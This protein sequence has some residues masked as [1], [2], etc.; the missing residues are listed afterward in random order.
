[1]TTTN[2]Q[3]RDPEKYGNQEKAASG[4]I[5]VLAIATLLALLVDKCNAQSAY[6][7][8]TQRPG[9]EIYTYK[10]TTPAAADSI[11]A[12]IVPGFSTA[13]TMKNTLYFEQETEQMHVYIERKHYVK[14]RRNGTIK[15]RRVKA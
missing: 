2:H 8:I 3:G 13:C 1:M 15:L 7:I 12:A 10:V 6:L 4:A 9:C 5:M 11:V 14:T